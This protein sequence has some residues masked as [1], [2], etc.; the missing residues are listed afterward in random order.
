MV[1][2]QVPGTVFTDT[3]PLWVMCRTIVDHEA[4]DSIQ[5]Q[6]IL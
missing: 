5:E 3:L 2:L 4:L 1:F 6:F